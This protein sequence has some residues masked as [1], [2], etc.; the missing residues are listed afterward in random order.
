MRGIEGYGGAKNHMEGQRGRGA[1]SDEGGAY[2]GHDQSWTRTIQG[3][4]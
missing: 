1:R 4:V 2:E 3:A